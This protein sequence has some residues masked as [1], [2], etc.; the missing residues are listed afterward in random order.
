MEQTYKHKQTDKS[1][2]VVQSSG[3]MLLSGITRG[4]L[5]MD[6]VSSLATLSTIFLR[7]HHL[8]C[9]PP[10]RGNVFIQLLRSRDYC[11]HICPLSASFSNQRLQNYNSS[12]PFVRLIETK[13]PL[14]IRR[15]GAGHTLQLPHRLSSG[16]PHVVSMF[17]RF[18]EE[19]VKPFSLL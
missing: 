4:G 5:W 7:L 12:K 2:T 6:R 17:T 11:P 3:C 18:T 10:Y 1:S 15:L 16:R 9:I 13:E 14:S 19:L 8:N